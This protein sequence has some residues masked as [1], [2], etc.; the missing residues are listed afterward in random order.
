M[1]ADVVWRPPRGRDGDSIRAESAGSQTRLATSAASF[2]SRRISW[3]RGMLCRSR[4]ALQ[5]ALDRPPRRVRGVYVVC[6]IRVSWRSSSVRHEEALNVMNT[7]TLKTIACTTTLLV[8]LPFTLARAPTGI[9]PA[10]ARAIAKE[11]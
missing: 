6:P 11:A 10:E 2:V 5:P 8:F 7:K 4:G 3:P 9:T 1:L